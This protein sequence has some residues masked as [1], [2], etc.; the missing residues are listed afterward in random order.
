[1][2]PYT[3]LQWVS[4][5]LAGVFLMAVSLVMIYSTI[6]FIEEYRIYALITLSDIII[7]D[8]KIITAIGVTPTYIYLFFFA[9]RTILQKGVERLKKGTLIGTIWGLFSLAC[10]VF[11]MVISWIIPLGLMALDYTLCD[12]EGDVPGLYYASKPEICKTIVSKP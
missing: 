9:F 12:E 5:K 1:M 4:F 7:Y 6:F 2:R 3:K 8:G 10:F 11:F